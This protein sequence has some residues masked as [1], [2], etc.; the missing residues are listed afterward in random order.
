MESISK[1]REKATEKRPIGAMARIIHKM[2]LFTGGFDRTPELVH[3]SFLLG[4]EVVEHDN[5]IAIFVKGR[6]GPV[7]RTGDEELL[8]DVEKLVVEQLDSL[9]G[10]DADA[11][12][13]ELFNRV[14]AGAKTGMHVDDDGDV[15]APFVSLDHFI[16]EMGMGE[17]EEGDPKRAVGRVDFFADVGEGVAAGIGKKPDFGSA[18]RR[19]CGDGRWC[20]ERAP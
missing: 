5:A 3:E 6:L 1:N 7:S 8:I 14:S 20:G 13:F 19:R 12:F 18:R 15:D 11:R 2:E 10:E 17:G 9:A 16:E 4:V